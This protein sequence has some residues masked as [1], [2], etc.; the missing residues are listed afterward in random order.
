MLLSKIDDPT[1]QTFLRGHKHYICST[2]IS[3]SGKYLA[4]GEKGTEA[5]VCVW[6]LE[7]NKLVFKFEEHY[8]SI[9]AIGFSHDDN[10]LATVGGLKDNRIVIWDLSTGNIVSSSTLHFTN[11]V[12]LEW[13]ELDRDIKRK[14]TG[15]YLFATIQDQAINI[16]TIDPYSG[17]LNQEKVKSG[18]FIRNYSTL[19]FSEVSGREKEYLYV[20]SETGDISCV[21]VRNRTMQGIIPVCSGGVRSL[22]AKDRNIYVGGGDGSVQIFEGIGKDISSKH[23][24]SVRGAVTSISIDVDSNRILLGTKSG[25]IYL[26]DSDSLKNNRILSE[27]HEEAINGVS[28]QRDSCDTFATC[29]KDGSVRCWSLDDYRVISQGISN[30]IPSSICFEREILFAGYESGNIKSFDSIDGTQ[31]W[32]MDNAHKHAVT[33]VK[34]GQNIKFFISGDSSGSLRLWEIKHRDLVCEFMEHGG[35]ITDLETFDNNAQLLSSSKDKS[36][37]CWDLQEERRAAKWSQR[38]GSVNSIALTNDQFSFMSVGADKNIT[39]WDLRSPKP[40]R[41]IPYGECQ[42]LWISLSSDNRFFATGASDQI[43]R[44]YDFETANQI[45]EGE[46]HSDSVVSLSFSP[47][48]KQI[49]SVG[50]DGCTFVWNIFE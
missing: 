23:K 7:E 28:F 49:V 20:G 19:S 41:T 5:D 10:L 13:G 43:V 47:D 3:S 18:S 31:L 42:P 34:V 9:E 6:D 11:R 8:H 15:K 14:S 21:H 40:V 1:D 36:I 2:A 32:S 44:L 27:S 30:G 4:T 17:K 50:N 45:G 26:G 29:S 39:H 46:G 35:G 16:W 22:Q 37:M 12:L 25:S 48:D 33:S 38:M 24:V